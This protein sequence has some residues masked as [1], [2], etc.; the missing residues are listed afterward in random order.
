L[1][2]SVLLLYSETRNRLENLL[3]KEL[4]LREENKLYTIYKPYKKKWTSLQFFLEKCISVQNIHT[5]IGKY[6]WYGNNQL[7]LNNVLNYFSQT[8]INFYFFHQKKRS[9]NIDFQEHLFSANIITTIRLTVT[10]LILI[11]CNPTLRG[12]TFCC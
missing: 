10:R 2:K 7:Y 6:I 11:G 9:Q 1:T 8:Q 5:V 3:K 12:T 4:L